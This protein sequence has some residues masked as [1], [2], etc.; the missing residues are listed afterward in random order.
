MSLLSQT[1]KLG[2]PVSVGSNVVASY[3]AGRSHRFVRDRV[4]A[5]TPQFAVLS[6]ERRVRFYNTVVID[7]LNKPVVEEGGVSCQ[8][9]YL[10]HLEREAGIE[11]KDP[12]G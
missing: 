8:L 1:D 11:G 9:I 3:M 4:I 10:E 2:Q 7:K 12:H 6:C 5:V